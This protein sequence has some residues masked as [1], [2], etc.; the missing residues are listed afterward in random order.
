MPAKYKVAAK[1]EIGGRKFES[2]LTSCGK[3]NCSKCPH[4]PY[5][6]ELIFLP[7]GLMRSKYVGKTHPTEYVRR[8]AA[9][10]V[11]A[12]EGSGHPAAAA[13]PLLY[14]HCKRLLSSADLS[15]RMCGRC[16]VELSALGVPV[17]CASCG[18]PLPGVRLASDG[19]PSC[20]APAPLSRIGGE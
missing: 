1:F 3:V 6:Y 16:G 18:F 4:G 7:G 20:L 15:R 8:K 5:W 10:P 9:R 12:S 14:C 2:R 17:M 11:A 19:C 13:A